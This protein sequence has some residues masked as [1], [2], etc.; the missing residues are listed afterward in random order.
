M[1]KLLFY[2]QIIEICL[3]V[4]QFITKK[5]EESHTNLINKQIAIINKKSYK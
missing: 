5:L 1:K 3:K 2:I 4:S